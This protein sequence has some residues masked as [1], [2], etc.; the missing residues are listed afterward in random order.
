MPSVFSLR[1][2]IRHSWAL[3]ITSSG[4][5]VL[6]A[7]VAAVAAVAAALAF[8]LAEFDLEDV[9]LPPPWACLGNS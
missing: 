5:D 2:L 3:A 1:Y 4:D 9:F 8:L 6:A 7:A